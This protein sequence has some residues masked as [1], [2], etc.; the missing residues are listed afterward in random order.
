MNATRT[1]RPRAAG[2]T[3]IELL[4]V[5]GIIAV[6]ASMLLPAMFAVSQQTKV[7]NTEATLKRICMALELY[8]KS[9]GTYPPDSLPLDAQII[10]FQGIQSGSPPSYVKLKLVATIP[11]GPYELAGPAYPPEALYYYLCNAFITLEPPSLNVRARAETA[12][13]NLNGI[14][15][16]IDAWGRPFLYNRSSFPGFLDTYYNYAGNPRHNYNGYDL[17]SV[18]PDAQTGTNNLPPIGP[19]TLPTFCSNAL[20]SDYGKGGDDI[21]NWNK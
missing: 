8:S 1:S 6:L 4:V 15:E 11:P 16:I 5:I 9:C 2:F 17:L 10:N 3:L 21:V 18:G 7:S 13:C 12:D 20:T 19:T 14:A